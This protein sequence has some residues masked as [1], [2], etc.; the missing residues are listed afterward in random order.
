MDTELVKTFLEVNRTRHF[1]KAA[2]NLYVTQAA[3]SARIRQLEDHLAVTLFIRS[4][5]NIQ[6]TAEGKRLIP[7]AETILMAWTRARQEVALKPELKNHVTIGATYGLWHFFLQDKLSVIHA[8]M[9]ELALNAAAHSDI[10]LRRLVN[11]G[12]LDLAILYEP[13]TAPNLKT[14]SLGKLRLVLTSSNPGSSVQTALKTNYVFVDWGTYFEMFHAKRFSDLAS[15][16]LHTDMASV[17]ESFIIANGGSAFLP[18]KLLPQHKGKIERVKDAPE[19]SREV[20][21][22]YRSNA[23]KLELIQAV[24]THM[25]PMIE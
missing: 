20:Y 8:E 3:V 9:P 12:V 10:E 21:A 15:P 14:Q 11:E 5:N 4:R 13:T 16:V 24:L 6:L 22:V 18:L 2:Q 25:R 7:Y 19:F 1:G 17:A 23:E